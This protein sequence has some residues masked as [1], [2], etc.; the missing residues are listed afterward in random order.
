MHWTY[1][2]YGIDLKRIK[3]ILQRKANAA[4]SSF[5]DLTDDEVKKN[6]KKLKRLMK[7][8]RHMAL[9]IGVDYRKLH[10]EIGLTS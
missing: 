7:V 9:I 1:L 2:L 5:R 10:V 4:E 6:Q 3:R 8:Q